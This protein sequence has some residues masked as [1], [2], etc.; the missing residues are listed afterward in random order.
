[1]KHTLQSAELLVNSALGKSPKLANKKLKEA[2]KFFK[3]GGY[4]LE[5]KTASQLIAENNLKLNF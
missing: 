5:E 4:K 3:Q 2:L 1:M